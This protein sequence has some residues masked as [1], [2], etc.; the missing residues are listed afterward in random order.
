MNKSTYDKINEALNDAISRIEKNAHL[1]KKGVARDDILTA[2]SSL[3][4]VKYLLQ[5]KLATITER[6]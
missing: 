3:A 5:V 4:E 6:E 1:V 2:L